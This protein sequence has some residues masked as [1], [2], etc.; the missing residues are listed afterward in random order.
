MATRLQKKKNGIFER[1]WSARCRRLLKTDTVV[2]GSKARLS[3]GARAQSPHRGCRRIS[4]KLGSREKVAGGWLFFVSGKL[5]F[6]LPTFDVG[7]E[8]GAAGEI[9]NRQNLL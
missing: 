9:L 2:K 3:I 6:Q 5:S 7:F 8:R 4:K 1:R